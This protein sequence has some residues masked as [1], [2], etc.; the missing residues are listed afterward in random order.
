MLCSCRRIR[1]SQV[2]TTHRLPQP[3][4]PAAHLL[5]F[6]SRTEELAFTDVAQASRPFFASSL[7]FVTQQTGATPPSQ[8]FT[9]AESA[10]AAIA[11][12][13]FPKDFAAQSAMF[14]TAAFVVQQDSSTYSNLP[15]VT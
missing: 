14:S 5:R 12:D 13:Q 9:P 3:P 1:W 15:Q 2:R 4:P 11:R 6:Y 8:F 10:L 7:A